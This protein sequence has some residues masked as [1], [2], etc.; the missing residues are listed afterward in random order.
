MNNW[1]IKFFIKDYQ[2]VKNPK[3]RTS[4]GNFASIFGIISNI[5]LC[6]TK[7]IIG[8]ISSSISIIADG[9]NNLTDTSSSIVTLAGFKLANRPE[10]SKHPYGHARFEY[11][12]GLIV[13]IS[14]IIVGFQ[15]L[16][17]SIN[18]ILHPEDVFFNKVTVITLVIAIIVKIWQ[19]YLYIYI[20]KKI[21][22]ITIKAVSI[23]SR[24]DVFVTALILICLFIGKFTGFSLDAYM[25]VLVALFIIWSGISLIL[26]TSS[27]LLGEAPSNNLVLEILNILNNNPNVLG[28]H[29]LMVHNYGPN[30]IFATIHVEVDADANLLE[31]H[32][33]IDNLEREI[34]DDLDIHIT[35]HM[36]PI[37]LNDPILDNLRNT[38]VDIIT[39]IE[40]IHSLHDFRIVPGPTH[41]NIIF[42]AVL[43]K[44][45]SLSENEIHDMV[46]TTLS[47]KGN[48]NIVITFDKIYTEL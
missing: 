39:S 21:D 47:K 45:C 31:S 6:T 46:Q 10:D 28:F 2:D 42:D 8:I 12:A 5:I 20:A 17:S 33:M 44:K 11:I 32:D 19:A 26:E 13:A 18:R 22:S 7:I 40:G 48:Y 24:N 27:P 43:E 4:Y 25:G 15:L 29:D 34:A 35:I 38:V 3:V 30:K 41:T 37:V 9:L 1:L 14:I 16:I 36:D 23:D